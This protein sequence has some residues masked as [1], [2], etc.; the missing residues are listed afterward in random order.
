MLGE[1]LDGNVEIQYVNEGNESNEGED[2]ELPPQMSA[3]KQRKIERAEADAERRRYIDEAIGNLISKPNRQ[4]L[5]IEEELIK[6]RQDHDMAIEN[7]KLLL[8][9]QRMEHETNRE[10]QRQVHDLEVEKQKL[11][12][13][14][15]QLE[16]EKIRESR[17]IEEGRNRDEIAKMQMNVQSNMLQMMQ[18]FFE[19]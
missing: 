8:E 12:L 10:S 7:K 3:A 19:K 9:K 17:K 14:K 4:R 15:Q 18:N 11:E 16:L 6:Q 13:E 1:I 2:E 5:T